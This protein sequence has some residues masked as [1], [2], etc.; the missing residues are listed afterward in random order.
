MLQTDFRNYS[1]DLTNLVLY[2]YETSSIFVTLWTLTFAKP[3]L[4]YYK[5]QLLFLEL[6]PRERERSG[7]I[8]VK[9]KVNYGP[10]GLNFEVSEINISYTFLILFDVELALLPYHTGISAKNSFYTILHP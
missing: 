10:L 9:I 4:H 5:W 7:T 1:K 2:L 8:D 6:V 3:Q